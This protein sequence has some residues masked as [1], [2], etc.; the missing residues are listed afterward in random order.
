MEPLTKEQLTDRII[1]IMADKADTT[2]DKI[3]MDAKIGSDLGFDSLD[4][5][6]LIM[7]VEKEWNLAIPDE[8]AEKITN[9]QSMVDLAWVKYQ[10]VPESLR[11]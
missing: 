10:E 4:A 9:V 3:T 6:E 7:E 1:A 2:P 5:V 8:E 11:K